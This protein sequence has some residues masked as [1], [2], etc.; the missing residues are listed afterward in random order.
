MAVICVVVVVVG[1]SINT[2]FIGMI[3]WAELGLRH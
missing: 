2:A 3:I 1:T